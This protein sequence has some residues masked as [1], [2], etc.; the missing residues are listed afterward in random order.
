LSGLHDALLLQIGE[1][2]P[3]GMSVD[4]ELSRKLKLC[5]QFISRHKSFF[6]DL[7]FY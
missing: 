1:G 5:W 4:H 7:T 6:I 2:A 3:N